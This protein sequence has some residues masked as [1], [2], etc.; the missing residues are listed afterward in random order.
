MR[1]AEQ[2]EFDHTLEQMQATALKDDPESDQ[3]WREAFDR[4]QIAQ[5]RLE[6]V[7]EKE[8]PPAETASAV[9]AKDTPP[10]SQPPNATAS[11]DTERPHPDSVQ[12]SGRAGEH[13]GTSVGHAAEM[14]AVHGMIQAAPISES[15]R[16]ALDVGVEVGIELG[17][18]AVENF[19]VDA[20]KA[21][22][23]GVA[24]QLGQA[25]PLD[26]VTEMQARASIEEAA[27]KTVHPGGDRIEPGDLRAVPAGVADQLGQARPLD[28][29][30][31][32]QAR[33]SIE[34]AA[35][36]RFHEARAAEFGAESE[37]T[38]AVET[39]AANAH[40]EVTEAQRDI[41]TSTSEIKDIEGRT[42]VSGEVKGGAD[43]AKLDELR[44]DRSEAYNRLDENLEIESNPESA[45]GHAE[46]QAAERARA[47][48]EQ[49]RSEAEEIR[50][51]ND[52][53]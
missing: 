18:R 33:A 37:V 50:R 29:V 16:L 44:N 39:A 11:T 45:A 51:R 47:D 2:K 28:P 22:P 19:D 4:N 21:V 7:G 8:A 26:P 25:R 23:A 1:D 40:S 53:T 48:A 30:T 31:E 14:A 10:D 13:E 24:D 52:H 17:K 46:R 36:S 49:A 6:M 32:M 15:S 9:A 27:S 20:L 5:Q 34:E 3:A 42:P 43:A 38:R 41:D 35:E 12:R